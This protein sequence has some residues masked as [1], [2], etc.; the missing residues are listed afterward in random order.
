MK[1][2][3]SARFR[4]GL[5]SCEIA[6]PFRT[7]M[8]GYASRRDGFD[9]VHDPLT[10]TAVY[11]EADGV[12][13]LLGCADLC[14]F[15]ETTVEKDL[16]RVA[17][18]IGARPDHVF[19]NASHTHGGPAVPPLS[20]MWSE[21][22]APP[23]TTRRYAAWLMRR[24]IA[25]ACRAKASA[26]PGTLWYGKGRS[27]L[28]MSRRLPRDGK[29]VNAPNPKG[30]VD[31][32]LRL[33]VLKD[34][35][36]A[37]K[38]VGMLLAC[39][40]V[41]T[42]DQHLLTADFVGAWRAAFRDAFGEGVAPFFL[43]GSGGDMRPRA[44][45][46]GAEWRRLRHAELASV[47]QELLREMAGALAKGLVEIRNPHFRAKRVAVPLP[48]ERRHTRREDFLKLQADRD[49]YVRKYAEISL[50]LLA[51]GKSLPD[52]ATYHVQTLW[53]NREF[54][55][56]GL[57]AEPLVGLGRRVEAAAKPGCGLLLGYTNGCV[58]YLPDS[59]E[60]LRGGYEADSYLYDVWS[61]PWKTG[62][63]RR[64]AAAVLR[65]LRK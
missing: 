21:L 20:P 63:E 46:S 51:Q 15:P 22:F 45:A 55:L 43:Q 9:G 53:L 13:A 57:D 58:T 30:E 33:L 24:V 50:R 25:T 65:P 59:R 42:G 54:A 35:R 31:D 26:E 23:K 16:A 48:L 56:I 41:C 39:H 64:I 44:A 40:P 38:A 11:L 1:P 10:F 2:P 37:M 49:P 14:N 18:A 61:G 27:R 5:A 7:T 47:G 6:P 34:A 36:G 60:I 17:H 12:P 4:F 8:H 62:T 52:V 32:R 19:L 28:P 3:R 29:I